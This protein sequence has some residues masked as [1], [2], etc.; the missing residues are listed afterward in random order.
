MLLT[1]VYFFARIVLTIME[2]D[3]M[4][5]FDELI[6]EELDQLKQFSDLVERVHGKAHPEYLV[7]KESLDKVI[8]GIKNEDYSGLDEAFEGASNATDGYTLPEGACE[9]FTYVYNTTKELDQAYKGG[10]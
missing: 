2:V 8:E 9:A 10:K 6:N 1:A 7:F 5:R 4:N 3:N